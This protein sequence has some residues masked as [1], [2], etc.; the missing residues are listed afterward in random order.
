MRQLAVVEGLPGA[1][2]TAQVKGGRSLPPVPLPS[3][4]E[5]LQG[6]VE[7]RQ[8]SSVIHQLFWNPRARSKLEEDPDAFIARLKVLPRVKAVLSMM[9]ATLQARRVVEPQF[10][11]WYGAIT[12]RRATRWLEPAGQQHASPPH[13]GLASV[14]A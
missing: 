13:S 10:S 5:V 9:Q 14:L 2:P 6:G 8:L 7:G 3:A 11:W 12:P 4:P 1:E